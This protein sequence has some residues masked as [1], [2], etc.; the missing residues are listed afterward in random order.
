MPEPIHVLYLDDD[1][2]DDPFFVAGLAQR[3]AR[4]KALPPCLLVHGSG[5]R[6]ER[7]LEAEGLFPERAGGL[8]RVRT[9]REAALVEQALRQVNRRLVGTL[10]DAVVHAVGFHGVDRGLLRLEADGTV[11]AGRVG[12]VRA[13]LG[14]RVVPVVS[15]LVRAGQRGAAQQAPLPAVTLALARALG[16]VVVVFFTRTEQPGLF[17]GEA[18]RPDAAV[19]ALPEALL[20]APEA[21]RAVAA[22]GLPA[23]LTSAAGLFGGEVPLGTKI[24]ATKTA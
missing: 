4:R 12:W 21:V 16:G 24:F 3:M 22:A 6:A 20:P 11:T 9:P 10:T 14:Q 23:L 8:V 13:L 19:E 18:L 7:L 2:L 15:T 17:E 1:H 5:E